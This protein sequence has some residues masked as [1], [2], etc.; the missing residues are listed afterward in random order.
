MRGNGSLISCVAAAVALGAAPRAAAQYEAGAA[1]AG[2]LA[3]NPVKKALRDG[4]VVIGATITAFSVDVAA[5]LAGTTFDFLWFEME[6]TGLSLETLRAMILAT[7]GLNAMPFTRVPWNEPWLA[8]RVLDV[9]SLGVIFPFVS[10]R[11]QA[12]KAV[13]SC[14]YPPRG[15]RGYGPAGAAAR[16]GRAG[17]EYAQW[18]DDNVLVVVIVETAEAVRNVDAIAA[19][20]GIDVVFIGI[21]DLSYSLGA[22]GKTDDPR[23]VQAIERVLAAAKKHGVPAGIPAGNPADM[24]KRAGQGFRFFQGPSDIALMSSAARTLLGQ[25]PG[26]TP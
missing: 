23:V 19:V 11:E 2:T 4:K 3:A 13:R 9:G 5:A 16:W 15:V 18:A 24:Q 17:A 10:T 6:H 21:N 8:K 7:R 26:R 22:R 20:P 14:K 1:A 25:V 12:E